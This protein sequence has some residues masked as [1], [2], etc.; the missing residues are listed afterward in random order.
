MRVSRATV[1]LFGAAALC[2]AVAGCG[3]PPTARWVE[4]AAAGQAPATGEQPAPPADPP[5][6]RR[7]SLQASADTV[8]FLESVLPSQPDGTTAALA[9]PLA[10]RAQCHEGRL[11]V[12][13][14]GPAGRKRTVVACDGRPHERAVG[15]IKVGDVVSV[16]TTG[17]KGTDFAIELLVK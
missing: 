8:Y 11:T 3:D 7:N 9:G 6:S 12:V 4:P 1:A 16:E 13:V 5:P 10:L 14:T 17:R 15:R 2:A